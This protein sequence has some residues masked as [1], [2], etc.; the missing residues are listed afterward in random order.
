MPNLI[1]ANSWI[2]SLVVHLG[3]LILL[4]LVTYSLHSGTDLELQLSDAAADDPMFTI[5]SEDANSSDGDDLDSE[6]EQLLAASE[7]SAMFEVDAEPLEFDPR[8]SLEDLAGQSDQ[9]SHALSGLAAT[10]RRIGNG[11]DAQFFGIQASGQDFVFIVDSSGSMRGKRWQNALRELRNSLEALHS[12]QRFYVIFFDHQT[13]LMFQGRVD[14]FRKSRD[15]KMV[16]ATQENLN[17]V[18]NWIRR[19]DLGNQTRP[20]VSFDYGLS[21]EPDV[22]FFLTDGEFDDETFEFL[23]GLAAEGSQYPAIYTVAFG[24]PRAAKTL[25]TIADRFRGRY[26]FVR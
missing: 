23:M 4:S 15:L 6:M 7:D 25:E 21:L 5:E 20:R 9:S 16:E 18:N 3:V 11:T 1:L 26:Q 24:N 2:V 22:I 14:R 13:H 17:R 19:V 8:F 12:S 10:D